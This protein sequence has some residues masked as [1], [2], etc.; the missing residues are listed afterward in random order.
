MVL[1]RMAERSLGLWGPRGARRLAALAAAL[2]AS[3]YLLVLLVLT[4]AVAALAVVVLLLGGLGLYLIVFPAGV[5]V[6]AVNRIIRSARPTRRDGRPLG[7]EVNRADQP[8]LWALVDEV[9]E[10]VGQRRVDGLRITL[11]GSAA[12]VEIGRSHVRTLSIP[13]TYLSVLGEE[14]LRG[15][16]A[17]ELYHFAHGDTRFARRLVS[18]RGALARTLWRLDR[19]GSVLRYPFRWYA[20][21]L[22][23]FLAS[24]SRQQEFAADAFAAAHFG[25][26][27]VARGLRITEWVDSAFATFWYD[28]LAPVLS[29]GLRP[30][31]STGYTSFLGSHLHG[32]LSAFKTEPLGTTLATHPGLV[33]RLAALGADANGI[34]ETMCP[35]VLL[36][37]E[38]DGLEAALLRDKQDPEGREQLRRVGWS[39]AMQITLPNAWRVAAQ[40]WAER[41]PPL[42]APELPTFI[43]EHV[44]DADCGPEER[45]RLAGALS[46]C[47]GSAL[48][49]AGWSIDASPG[50]PV[51]LLRG[52]QELRPFDELRAIVGSAL[53]R[54]EWA[55]RCYDAGIE[56]LVLTAAAAE[57]AARDPA[58]K[59][60]RVTLLLH[61]DEARGPV[62]RGATWLS[63]ITGAIWLA[64]AVGGAV[65]IGS[66]GASLFLW[67]VALLIACCLGWLFVSQRSLRRD[68]P[69]I[70]F[71]ESG[72]VLTHRGLLNEP[73]RVP[74]N[75]IRVVAFDSRDRRAAFRFPIFADSAWSDPYV[76]AAEPQGW[77]WVEGR[78]AQPTPYFGLRKHTPN[79]LVLLDEPV[80]GPPVRRQRLHGPLNGETLTALML[81][82]ADAGEAED[83]LSTIGVARRLVVSDFRSGRRRNRQLARASAG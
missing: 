46:C 7:I 38:L 18:V 32:G 48:V 6:A 59:G 29:E 68:A 3:F 72:L 1:G 82:V 81:T 69:R 8:R 21:V 26:A 14:E 16:V 47:L 60:Q 45:L 20:R 19:I 58:S 23:R 35:A 4:G 27:T 24:L 22:S 62:S 51:R 31:V 57:P 76:Q 39:E 41:L 33:D 65:Q 50:A 56:S 5:L 83:A 79:L 15:V 11:T 78:P 54:A 75:A 10:R 13:L 52:H 63:W 80:E 40:A 17:H 36:V 37:H 25:A 67:A 42:T 49:E 73:L 12:A 64:I 9:C 61:N 66:T 44:G 74:T 77:F 71:D 34:P 43:E 28:E 70:R 2:N 30:S 55:D 53:L